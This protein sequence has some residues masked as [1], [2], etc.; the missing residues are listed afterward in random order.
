MLEGK[1]NMRQEYKIEWQIPKNYEPWDV[2]QTLPSP[3]SKE[4]TEIYNYSVEDDGFYFLA[5]FR[6]F[7]SELAK[8]IARYKSNQAVPLGYELPESAFS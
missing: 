5:K 6:F 4:M 8:F 1:I 7:T 3:I 2:L